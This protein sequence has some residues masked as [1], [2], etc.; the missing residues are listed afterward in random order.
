MNPEKKKQKR[1]VGTP[2][3]LAVF[4]FIDHNK[5]L[6]LL[7]VQEMDLENQTPTWQRWSADKLF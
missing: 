2:I 7:A 1:V 6:V 4:M 3:I 5:V